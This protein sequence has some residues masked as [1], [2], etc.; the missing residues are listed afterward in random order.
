MLARTKEAYKVWHNYLIHLTRV[1]RY[2]IGVKIDETFTSILETI[3]RA[4]FA[5]DKFEKLSLVS[6]AIGKCDLLKF[7]LQISWEQKIIDNKIYSS[8][9]LLLDE[10]GRMLGGWKK[11]LN[12]KTP[13]KK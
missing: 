11:N 13:A 9:I 5:Y 2:T 4:T 12:E 1:D 8:L 7:F 6:G 10:V 3:F